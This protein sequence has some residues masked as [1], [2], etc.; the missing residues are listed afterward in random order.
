[1]K[2]DQGPLAV[3]VAGNHY[4][5]VKIQPVQFVE[6][7]SLG[8]CE[9]NIVKYITRARS[10]NG[11]EDIR[12]A[13]HY[14]ELLITLHRANP[15]PCTPP[16]LKFPL[17]TFLDQFPLTS[18]ERDAIR[19]VVYWRRAK[20]DYSQNNRRHLAMLLDLLASWGHLEKLFIETTQ[21]KA[22]P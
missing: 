17:N 15:M 2:S 13:K 18:T 21:P 22:T 3:Q 7:N 10:K 5:N 19:A 16:V 6:H 11:L 12:K 8:F 1:M 9:G 4:K 20:S 14:L